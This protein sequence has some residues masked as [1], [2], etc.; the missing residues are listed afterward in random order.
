V[1]ISPQHL[2]D[3]VIRPALDHL[4]EETGLPMNSEA[5]VMLLLGTQAHESLG[6]Y[7]LSQA[8]TGPARG[9]YQMEVA[10]HDWLWSDYL[11][12]RH[13]IANAIAKPGE[14]SAERM[15]YDL[16]YATMMARVYY[17]TKPEPIPDDLRGQAEYWKKHWNTPH[18]AGTVEKYLKDYNLWA[19]LAIG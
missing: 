1:S 13:N 8:P 4:A 2:L 9:G 12:R 5:A 11:S 18:G 3:Y 6:H 16:R 14:I 17:W 19:K 7:W 10:T 15:V